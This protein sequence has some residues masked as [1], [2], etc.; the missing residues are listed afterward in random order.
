M[1]EQVKFFK[2]FL[3][4]HTSSIM[5]T[6]TLQEK[7]MSSVEESSLVES[8]PMPSLDST[9][10][11]SPEPRTPKERLIHPSEIPIE[12]RDFGN[13]LK[14]FGHEKLT[15]PSIEVSPKIEPSKKWLL[16]V[17]RSSEAIRILSPSTTMPCSLTGTN[18]EASHNP[19]VETSI[20]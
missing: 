15:R 1:T 8:E 13:T 19:T 4:R 9:H 2:N 12:L 18:I 3:E 17:K 10:E 11:P 5:K 20:M 7:V 6:R 16:E 14:Y